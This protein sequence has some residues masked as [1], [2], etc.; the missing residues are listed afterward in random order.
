MLDNEPK[1]LS[2][3][4]VT[5]KLFMLLLSSPPVNKTCH[6]PY[7]TLCSKYNAL[8]AGYRYPS[9]HVHG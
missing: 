8:L 1:E 4:I 9:K 3:T 7:S 5:N 6:F 2:K